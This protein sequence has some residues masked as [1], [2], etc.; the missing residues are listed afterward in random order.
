M[1][2]TVL[3]LTM[4]ASVLALSACSEDKAA[5]DAIIATS[6]VG[7]I[8]QAELYKEMKDAIGKQVVESLL[9]QQTLENEYKI[10]D[11]ELK[12]EIAKQKE[13]FGDNFELVLLQNN[14]TEE[15]FGKIIK[16]QMLEQ[17][18]VDS[19]EISDEEIKAG[20]EDMKKEVH[21]RHILV[22]DKKTA[23]EVLAKLKDKGD[24]AALAAEYSIEPA[25]KESKGDLG[26]FGPGAMVAE[27]E[28]AAFAMKK[29]EIS[30]PVETMHGF[31]II[32]LLD[33]R[34][35]ESEK[36]DEELKAEVEKKLTDEK[37]EEKIT[38]LLKAAD[39]KIEN[40]DFKG[41]LEGYLSTDKK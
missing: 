16:S 6:K 31:H 11:K 36:T 37:V 33:T 28:K 18:L 24:F 25:A 10:T 9:L 32:E 27:F 7:D 13:Q 4:A 19:L 15:G 3:A 8:T 34:V 30:E 40:A 17:K 39:I 23:E 5:D 35:A 21:A 14:T 41:A 1:K 38:S 2:K 29:G 12:D 26:W 20:I 22:K